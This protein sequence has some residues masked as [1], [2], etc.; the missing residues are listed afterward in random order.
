MADT[1]PFRVLSIDGGGM[2]GLYTAI[3]LS[4]LVKQYAAN[5]GVSGLDVGKGFDMIVGTSTGGILAC[6]LVAGIPLDS[7]ADLYRD[8]GKAIFPVKLPAGIGLSLLRQLYTRPRRIRE[9]ATALAGVL[10]E[11]FNGETIAGVYSRRGIALAITAVEM[12]Q[13]RSW[14]FKTPHLGGHRD[15]DFSLADVCIA[16]SA[17][18]IY[19]SLALVNDPK[20]GH[21][22]IFVDGGLWANN[23][24]LVGLIDALDMT[25][26]GDRIEIY[27]LGTCARPAGD[28][29][30]PTALDWGLPRWK[31]GGEI[32]ALS[33]DAQE[34]AYDNMARMIAR[35]VNRDCHI[36]RFPHRAVSA[37]AMEYLDLDETR[38]EA[39][40]VLAEQAQNDVSHT[41]SEAR[42]QHTLQGELLNMLFNEIPPLAGDE[43][44]RYPP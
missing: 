24:V 26:E 20:T 40:R 15:D 12:A 23:P 21:D 38:P 10:H 31:F 27:S 4:S 25:T 17:A 16:T 36:V 2:R 22:H 3:Y 18:P 33:I 29:I 35:H 5:R 44:P 41:L 19:R 37:S 13:H 11:Q 30:N 39:T 14:V 34:Y 43:K 9:G 7:V 32:A 1:R 28:V 8:H 6:A 42:R